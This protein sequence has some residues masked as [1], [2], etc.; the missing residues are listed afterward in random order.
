MRPS[1]GFQSVSGMYDPRAANLPSPDVLAQGIVED[2]E[3]AI[4]EFAQ[5]AESLCAGERD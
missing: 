4:G 2:L 1:C 3:A 5:I